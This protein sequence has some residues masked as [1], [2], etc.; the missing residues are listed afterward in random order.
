[1]VSTEDTIKWVFVFVCFL[2]SFGSGIGPMK[3]KCCKTDKKKIG[4][5]NTFSGGV[6]LGIAFIHMIPETANLYYTKRLT[7]EL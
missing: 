3:A 5:L 6:F 2:T 1:M 7:E 4:L